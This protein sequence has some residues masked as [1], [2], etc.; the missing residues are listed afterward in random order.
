MRAFEYTTPATLQ[1]A[2]RMLGPNTR[3][4]AGGTDLITLMKADLAAPERLLNVKPLLPRG[5]EARPDGLEIGALSTLAEIEEHEVINAG[6]RALA[7]AAAVAASPQIRNL[8]TIGGNLLQRPRCWYYRNARI[9]CWLKGASDCPAREGE[10][11]HHAIFGGGP[12]YAVHPSDL[13]SAL[14]A[15]DAALWIHGRRGERTVELADF[16]A[17]PTAERRVET[18]L[19]PDE[20]ILGLRLP[21]HPPE[22]RS[23]YLKAMDRASFAFALTGVACVL[24]LSGDKIAHARIV[25]SGVAP[26][27]WRAEAAE[28]EL[29]GARATEERFAAAAA[30]TVQEAVPLRHNSYKVP[31]TKALVRKALKALTT[32]G[33]QQD[34]ACK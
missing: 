26:I 7:H 4:L 1:E 2:V 10:N 27:P 3:A 16:L 21:P 23:C 5:I 33:Q 31:L 29:Y 14:L 11:R 22:T 32:T 20:L 30:A 18:L 15:F 12:C 6:Y 13:A 25:L 34:P 9:P 28:R 8:A 24:R 17:L 19:E